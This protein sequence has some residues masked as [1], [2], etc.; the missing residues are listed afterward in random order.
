M[1]AGYKTVVEAGADAPWLVMV[2][3]MS[4]DH[5]LFS[6][7]VD[8]FKDR[9]RIQLI[10]L[11]GHGLS[12]DIP[13]PFGHAE[14]AAQVAGAMD[15]AGVERC[16]YWG[17]HTGAALGLLLLSQHADRFGSLIL[18][19]PVFPGRVPSSA[20]TALQQA[21]EIALARGVPAALR[22]WYDAG[23]WFDVI[24]EHPQ[25]CRADEHWA[26]LCRFSGAPW[27]FDGKAA[28]V[29][30]VDGRLPS[31]DVPVL[32][33]NGEHDHPQ[34]VDAA[35]RLENLFPRARRATIPGGG[36]YPA[37]EFPD[38]VDP[39]VADFLSSEWVASGRR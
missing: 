5:R 9:Y 37:W 34:Y 15:R 24:R 2:H 11:P 20:V 35:K 4:H 7:Q 32:L 22:Q 29:A 31:I 10:D 39:L 3:G 28:P 8:D 27:L 1:A 26:M 19:G 23:A 38:R 12:T 33:I 25:E 13:G 17:N 6:A 16:H 18:E 21:R 30:A 36:G 14:L